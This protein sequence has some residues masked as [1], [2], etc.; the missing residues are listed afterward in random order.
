[1]RRFT[2]AVFAR[3]WMMARDIVSD[4]LNEELYFSEAEALVPRSCLHIWLTKVQRDFSRMPADF[5]ATRY[6]LSRKVEAHPEDPALLSALGLIDGA[7][8]R[9]EEAIKEAKRAV[10]MLPISKDA[11]DGPSLVYNLAAVYALANKPNLAFE[12]LAFWSKHQA[13]CFTDHLGLIPLGIPSAK[14]RALKSF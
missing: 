7:L 5:A 6:Q 3:D 4:D 10:E 8:G 1:M 11:W 9:A 14:I 13:E 2:H 12:A